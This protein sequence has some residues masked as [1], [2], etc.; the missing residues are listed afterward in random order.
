MQIMEVSTTSLCLSKGVTIRA[1]AGNFYQVKRSLYYL[2]FI[3]QTTEV[4]LNCSK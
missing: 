3:D 4:K 1:V 2:K